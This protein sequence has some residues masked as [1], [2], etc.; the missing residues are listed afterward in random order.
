MTDLLPAGLRLAGQSLSVRGNSIQ[1]R[2]QLLLHSGNITV[3]Y[4]DFQKEMTQ[5]HVHVRR[6]QDNHTVRGVA[7]PVL[8][9]SVPH[10]AA[11]VE[12]QIVKAQSYVGVNAEA[13]S[14][15]QQ[16][17]EVS[18]HVLWQSFPALVGILGL[19]AVIIITTHP[20][21]FPQGTSRRRR[22]ESR[23]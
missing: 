5:Y 2:L 22:E 6:T 11:Q 10:G 17:R 12:K 15:P 19:A 16:H 8:S 3:E 18:L 14:Q 23:S 4:S 20:G 13:F 1:V 9:P 21:D 7:A